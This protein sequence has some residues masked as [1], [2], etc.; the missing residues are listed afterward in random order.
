[1]NRR[2]PR[3]LTAKSSFTVVWLCLATGL[4]LAN[5]VQ[6]D[7]SFRWVN[8]WGVGWPFLYAV[9]GKSFS[10]LLLNETPRLGWLLANVVIAA[11]LLTASAMVL[12][13]CLARLTPPGQFR[14]SDLFTVVTAIAVL[15]FLV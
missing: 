3:N 1:M 5:L 14:L 11:A 4:T 15:I 13:A 7:A 6:L 8:W 9:G 2:I 10:Y 12:R